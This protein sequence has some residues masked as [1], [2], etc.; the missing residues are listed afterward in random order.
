M[1]QL[2][3]KQQLVLN[4]IVAGFITIETIGKESNMSKSSLNPILSSLITKNLILR[5]A[6][7]TYSSVGT[8]STS[9]TPANADDNTQTESIDEQIISSVITVIIPYFKDEAVGE[10]LKYAFRSWEKNF[11]EDF[12]VIVVGDHEDWFSPDLVHIPHEP[13][14]ITEVCNC[15]VPALIRNPQADIT[16]KILTVIT[17]EN[18]TNGF[19]YSN[20]D[21]FLLGETSLADI[22]CLK[23]FVHNLEVTGQ[24]KGLYAQNNRLTAKA[25]IDAGLPIVRYGT[26]TPVALHGDKLVEIIEKYNAT[27]NGYPIESL[28]NNEMFPQARPI[29]LDGGANDPILASAYRSDIKPEVLAKV[30]ESRKF[31]NCDSKGWHAVE[32][33]LK[34]AF[35][36]PSRFEK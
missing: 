6:E 13:I 1:S 35:P 12:R 10:E 3:D 16:N 26:H 19:I 17:A 5:N 11:K 36:I 20:D 27:E 32:P 15:P 28:F 18:I 7:G 14:L 25:L 30:F 31:L 9:T 23:A 21:I 34:Q 22:E 33:F 29:L 2:T 4:L 8:D 24:G